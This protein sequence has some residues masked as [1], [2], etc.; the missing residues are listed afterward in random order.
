L[1]SETFKDDQ[2][3]GDANDIDLHLGETERIV[4]KAFLPLP[5]RG[6]GRDAVKIDSKI[7]GGR[8]CSPVIA[9]SAA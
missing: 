9:A 2:R 8:V 3:T 4:R 7:S 1:L 5:S 6:V